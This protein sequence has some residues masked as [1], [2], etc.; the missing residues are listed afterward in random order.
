[1]LICRK[2]ILPQCGHFILHTRTFSTSVKPNKNRNKPKSRKKSN[3]TKANTKSKTSTKNTSQNVKTTPKTFV[4]DILSNQRQSSPK[5]ATT[6]SNTLNIHINEFYEELFMFH[7]DKPYVQ[8]LLCDT[9][10]HM[11][12]IQNEANVQFSKVKHES[13]KSLLVNDMQSSNYVYDSGSMYIQGQKENISHAKQLL[14]KFFQNID[15]MALTNRFVTLSLVGELGTNR[16]KIQQMTGVTMLILVNDNQMFANTIDLDSNDYDY[17]HEFGRT[18]CWMVSNEIDVDKNKLKIEQCKNLIKE[19]ATPEIIDIGKYYNFIA[20]FIKRWNREFDVVIAF[21]FDEKKKDKDREKHQEKEKETEKEEHEH[22]LANTAREI[23]ILGFDE[24]RKKCKEYVKKFLRQ[25]EEFDL[26]GYVPCIVGK[27]GQYV[28]EYQR[29]FNIQIGSTR[30]GTNTTSILLNGVALYQDNDDINNNEYQSE[31]QSEFNFGLEFNTFDDGLMNEDID[32]YLNISKIRKDY[33]KT[34]IKYL[35]M[36]N[37]I[38][39]F[40][41][42]RQARFNRLMQSKEWRTKMNKIVAFGY[43][44]TSEILCF[45]LIHTSQNIFNYFSIKLNE[46]LEN[47]NTHNNS[48]NTNNNNYSYESIDNVITLF[49]EKLGSD[50]LKFPEISDDEKNLI[51]NNCDYKL[52]Q[53]DINSYLSQNRE[54]RINN[55]ENKIFE[56]IN[57]YCFEECCIMLDFEHLWLPA[58]RGVDGKRLDWL[59]DNFLNWTQKQAKQEK[60]EKMAPEGKKIQIPDEKQSEVRETDET[61]EADEIDFTKIESCIPDFLIDDM[62]WNGGKRTYDLKKEIGYLRDSDDRDHKLWLFGAKFDLLA[63]FV[64]KLAK[65]RENGVVLDC[66]KKIEIG[67]VKWLANKYGFQTLNKAP[68]YNLKAK[69]AF[70]VP[71]SLY[72]D[73]DINN[74]NNSDK[75]NNNNHNNKNENVVKL[76]CFID[77]MINEFVVS[78]KDLQK[79]S[80]AMVAV[81]DKQI[82]V[83]GFKES[84]CNKTST[85]ISRQI[86]RWVDHKMTQYWDNI[87]K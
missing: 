56:L 49:D 84:V 41:D 4:S 78:P 26:H 85:Y 10:Y 23:H 59:I 82:Y 42:V 18:S 16:N 47:N 9:G 87:V 45:N 68:L 24:N 8:L 83:T 76:D 67:I 51:V 62:L 81:F 6:S 3:N 64:D 38:G 12:R 27:N 74:V 72:G 79:S 19:I 44:S 39:K 32:Y 36:N 15:Y 57:Y 50:F 63:G 58:I 11:Y 31:S 65:L 37:F 43:D 66:A 60:Q 29:L 30:K 25:C 86:Y 69:V 35:I 14:Y 80:I 22:V 21:I 52:L 5:H 48:N 73:L 1:M 77:K 33:F 71:V 13:V 20:R 28:D 7:N 55:D 40:D 61:D 34:C 46:K 2:S 53:S 17:D 75:N 70:H 54:T